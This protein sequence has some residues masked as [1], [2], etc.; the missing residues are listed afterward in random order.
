MV[1]AAAALVIA[2]SPLAHF[3]FET[4]HQE[5]GIL[6]VLEWVG[7]RRGAAMV[8]AA[9]VSLGGRGVLMP[10]WGGVGKTSTMARLTARPDGL[11]MGD[12]WAWVDTDQTLLGYA[13]PMFLKPHHRELYP[14]VFTERRKP[15]APSALTDTVASLATR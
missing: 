9:T 13:T 14:H 1:V 15:M 11:F 2:N 6:P 7:V 8:H 10:A 4:L 12:D 5:L 3:Y